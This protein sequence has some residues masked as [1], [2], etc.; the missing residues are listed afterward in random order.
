M[1]KRVILAAAGSGKT[2][3][4]VDELS[5]EKRFLI[6][7]YT[8][9]NYS[10][11]QKKIHKKYNGVWPANITL[12][13]Y[14]TFLYR[15]CYKPFL[16]DKVKAKGLLYEPCP[17][18]GAKQGEQRY[19]KSC[20]RYLYSNRLALLLEKQR[21][22][23]DVKERITTYFDEF[24][25]DEVQDIAGRDFTFLEHLMS[26]PC[27]ILLVGD[28]YQHTFDTSRDGNTN[29]SLF[30]DKSK[31]ENRFR[32]Q[33]ITVDNTTLINSWR[34]SKNVCKYVRENIGIDIYSNRSD[35]DNTSI[36]YISDVNVA[37]RIITDNQIIK[38]HYRNCCKFGPYHRNWGDTKGE[39]CYQDVCVLLNKETLDK[40][41][42]SKLRELAPSTKNRLYVAITRA[43]GNVFLID[44]KL[45]L[46]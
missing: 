23:G 45:C 38:L 18:K 19:Y 32:R 10:N 17:V 5:T 28:F 9:A 43:R 21:V 46:C 40:Y 15:F 20:G 14:F 33:G 35:T 25:I 44:E 8:N 11:L 30:S 13:G 7:T 31:Y 6:V 4:I 2:S 42:K 16:A 12:M 27:N 26:A 24:I 22:L 41:R 37:R 39:D 29:S 34:C 3:H 1:D 36:E